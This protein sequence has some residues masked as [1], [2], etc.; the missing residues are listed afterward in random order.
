MLSLGFHQSVI[1]P[2]V[3]K[4]MTP[5]GMGRLLPVLGVID[6][7]ELNL[8]VLQDG[9]ESAVICLTDELFITGSEYET[10]CTLVEKRLPGAGL[11]LCATHDH[12]ATPVPFGPETDEKRQ[13]IRAPE[14]RVL[15]A[16]ADCLDAALTRMTPVEVAAAR[17]PFP[18]SPSRNR[19]TKLSNGAG[20]SAF[21][22]AP[23]PPPGHKCAGRAGAD[24]TEI[25]V[26]A[27]REPGS[28]H[29]KILLTSYASHIHF[30]EI[31]YFNT[32]AAGAARNALRRLLPHTHPVYALSFPGE[33]AMQSCHPVRGDDDESARV[34]WQKDSALAYGQAFAEALLKG[35]P[36]LHY[37]PTGGLRFVRYEEP[38]PSNEEF[39]LVETL[40]IG[41]HAIC[42]V[43]G[44]FSLAFEA[45]LRH[46]LPCASLLSLG[47]N[48]SWVG[49][50][51]SALAFEEGSY[52]THR[53]PS[54]HVPYPTPTTRAKS[55]TTTGD[56]MIAI[57][58]KQLTSLFP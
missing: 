18:G 16:F 23:M 36:T 46:Q 7:L 48:R 29:P 33:I 17:I 47:Y 12:S 35:L 30:Y 34:Q 52:E 5:S 4:D 26:L 38:G 54:D 39:I 25:D 24:P 42:S 56:H 20:I 57:A 43:S 53:G 11:I 31:P 27:F 51:S 50:V 58:K 3:L 40:R 6:D 14:E 49:Y 19:R 37:A 32:E 2:P 1:T 28:S 8:L 9:K 22:A 44:E 41:N 15:A 10:C 13:A 45:L 55:A 21:G